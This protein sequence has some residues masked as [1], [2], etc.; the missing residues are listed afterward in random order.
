[1]AGPAGGPHFTWLSV[2]GRH[3]STRID[4]PANGRAHAALVIV[5]SS[6]REATVAFRVCRVLAVRA[7]ARGLVAVSPALTGQGDSAPADGIEDLAGA[8]RRDVEL[9]IELARSIVGL[10]LGACLAGAVAPGEGERRVLWQ[11]VTG[12]AF[13]RSQRALRK[14]AVRPPALADVVELYADTLTRT[15]ADSLRRLRPAKAGPGV[16][17]RVEE[18]AVARQLAGVSTYHTEVPYPAVDGVLDELP[19]GP[20]T[21]LRP[22]HP[23]PVRDV[24]VAVPGTGTRPAAVVRL[25]EEHV[26]IGPRRVPGVLTSRAD[27]VR[28]VGVLLSAI[29]T[30]LRSG[31]AQLWA[32]C[33]RELAAGGAEV[34]RLD[35]HRL[36]DDLDPDDPR[37]PDA[38]TEEAAADLEV[39][40]A[41]LAGRVGR[42]P[43]GLGVCAG[44]WCLFKAAVRTPI[45]HIVSV[46]ALHWDTDTRVYTRAFYDRVNGEEMAF[47]T[48]GPTV[49]E[50]ESAGS[51]EERNLRERLSAIGARLRRA[52]E[53][54]MMRLPRLGAALHGQ[55]PPARV[56]TLL[57]PVPATTAID[58]VMGESEFLLFRANKGLRAVRGRA[59][60]PAPVTVTLLPGLDHSLA[61]QTSRDLVRQHLRQ[62]VERELREAGVQQR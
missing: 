21:P 5:P 60:G 53:R 14:V 57:Q 50:P 9:A 45:A 10:R 55:A 28:G 39:A 41:L 15:Q 58:L 24:E 20:G 3:L 59:A 47:L 46:N 23:V 26:R 13:V 29:G 38:Y 7:A 22:F 4:L 44:A 37:D 52:R 2:D 19:V 31:P 40:A 6:G 51:G 1:M 32:A 61:A 49:A 25:R 56:S 35:R 27:G 18:P 33:A 34:L 16:C 54:T 36:G 48:E 43:V 30:E 62:V 11:P 8:W 42:P 17:V 12:A